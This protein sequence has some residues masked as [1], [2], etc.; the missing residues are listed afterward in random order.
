MT[1][2]YFVLRL[3]TSISILTSTLYALCTNCTCAMR[4]VVS[5][6][7]KHTFGCLWETSKARNMYGVHQECVIERGEYVIERGKEYLTQYSVV[8]HLLVI[9]KTFVAIFMSVNVHSLYNVI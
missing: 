1:Y 6:K 3:L 9:F 8:L 2:A 5:A 4:E 7:V